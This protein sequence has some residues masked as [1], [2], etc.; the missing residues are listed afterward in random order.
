MQ[1][2]ERTKARLLAATA[3]LMQHQGFAATGLSEIL[4]TSGVPRGSLYFHF[5]G[6][7]ADLT[8]ASLRAGTQ[9]WR[10]KLQRLL[11]AHHSGPAV[12]RAA[13]EALGAR[14]QRTGWSQGCPVATLTLELATS[15]ETV[16][17]VCA[18][19]FLLWEGFLAEVFVRDGADVATAQSWATLALASIEGALLL[20]RTYQSLVPLE[21]VATAL[22]RLVLDPANGD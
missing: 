1:K 14:L 6:G 5:P 19:H 4:R 16:R 15:D 21:R 18:E 22:G 12:L 20:S 2:G 7:K 10:D 3:E 9:Y 17:L 11:E 13:C 8:L